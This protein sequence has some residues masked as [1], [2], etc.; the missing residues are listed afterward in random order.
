MTH[1]KATKG[2]TALALTVL[3]TGF[4][5]AAFESR[6]V[7]AKTARAVLSGA[8]TVSLSVNVK[9]LNGTAATDILWN[10]VTLPVA[11]GFKL[12]DTYLEVA[13]V[14]TQSGSGVQIYTD[15]TTATPAFSGV[16]TAVDPS[17]L[18]DNT[19]TAQRLPVAWAAKVPADP[20]PVATNPNNNQTTDPNASQWVYMK[21]AQTKTIPNTTT[22]VFVPGQDFVTIVSGDKGGHFTQTGFFPGQFPTLKVYL[23]ADFGGAVTPRTYST[24]KLTVESFVQ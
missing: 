15:N 13:S 24:N 18:V 14:L 21:D 22:T 4:S 5:H 8:G 2:L 23:A 1:S 20:Q 7:V 19:N 9:N 12:A 11:G 16:P 3:V 17:G 10:A 6:Q